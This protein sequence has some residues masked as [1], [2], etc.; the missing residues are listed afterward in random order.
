MRRRRRG[1]PAGIVLM[2]HRIGEPGPDP[3]QLAVTPQH[4]AEHLATIRKL[5]RPVPL[6]QLASDA[7]ANTLVNGTLAVTFDDGYA[8]NLLAA[9]PLLCDADVPATVY[10]TTGPTGTSQ[11]FWW[12]ELERI[13]LLPDALPPELDL[14]IAGKHRRWTLGDAATGAWT[15]TRPASAARR[16]FHHDVWAPLRALPAPER[17]AVLDRLRTWSG[18]PATSRP[19]HR[20]M[21]P[22]EIIALEDGGLLEAG[23]HTVTHPFLPDLASAD[24]RHEMSQSL[25]ALESILGRRQRS[26]SYPFGGATAETIRL[27]RELGVREAVGIQEETTWH[28]SDPFRLPRFAVRNWDGNEFEGRLRTWFT[29]HVSD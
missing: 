9:K 13:L 25:A 7:G 5:A 4:F 2:Y 27:A 10:V 23:G 21:S 6:G 20:V 19:S 12:D 15:A 11:E 28:L 22:A 26:F 24:Q 29:W 17:A 14:E 8:D 16:R 18:A 3:W 1:R